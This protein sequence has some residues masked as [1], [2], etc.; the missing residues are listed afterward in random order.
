MGHEHITIPLW[1]VLPFAGILLSIAFLPLISPFFW[2]RNYGKIALTFAAPM[3]VYVYTLNIHWLEHTAIEYVSFIALLGALFIISGGIYIRGSGLGRPR[4]NVIILFLGTLL[5]SFIGTTGASM[6]L[7]RPLVRTNLK[8]PAPYLPVLFFLFLVSNMGGLLTPLGDPPLF[9]GFLKGV[10][11]FWTL[12]LFPMWC[13]A[14]VALLIAYVIVDRFALR[15]HTF[16]RPKR[17]RRTAIYG[18]VNFLLL[19]GVLGVV[20]LYGNLPI[21]WGLWRDVIQVCGMGLMA[22]GSIWL[23]PSFSRRRNRFT[24]APIKEVAILFAAIFVCMIPALKLLEINGASLGVTEPWQ[25]YWFTGILSSFLDN[26]PTYLAFLS[27]A[28]TVPY[29]GVMVA[30]SDGTQVAEL[31]LEAISVGAVFM[32]ALTY[33]GNG[34]NFMVK[35][36]AEENGVKMPSFLGYVVFSMFFLMPVLFLVHGLFF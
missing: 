11:F 16:K 31:F 15:N 35:A 32:G 26:A 34:P 29:E 14:S 18:S 13:V 19:A 20:I 30:L 1:A 4:D 6:L 27:L 36:I 33:I 5:A 10:P 8:R 2:H 9:L 7:I 24:Y 12:K 3:A 25:F 28:K 21:G 17:M 22:L 23:S